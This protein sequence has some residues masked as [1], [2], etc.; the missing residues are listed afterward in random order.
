MPRRL[1]SL[2]LLFALAA[3]GAE[4][5]AQAPV[6]AL[7]L[8]V[9]Q[10]GVYRVAGPSLRDAGLVME[11]LAVENLHLST[12]GQTVP[13][14]L[15]GD[16]LVFYGRASRSRYTGEQVYILR[17]GQPGLAM[18]EKSATPAG[19]ALE[20]VERTLT[21]EENWEYLAESRG[22]AAGEP[23]FWQSLPLKGDLTLPLAIA[24]PAGGSGQLT[25]VFYG[26]SHHPQEN[27]DHT[28]SLAVNGH[29]QQTISWEG[30][31]AYS[32]TLSLEPGTLVAGDNTL[33]LANVP[34]TFLDLMKLDRLQLSYPALPQAVQDRLVFSGAAGQVTLQG[35][36]AT[37]LLL[38]IADPSAPAVLVGWE[39]TPDG[40]TLGLDGA[41]V[42]AATGPDGFLQPASIA[43]L[44]SGGWQATDNQADLLIVTT[45]ALA[46]ALAP[47][48]AAREEQGL[49]VALAPVAEVYDEFGA[50][51]ATPE[52]INRFLAYTLDAWSPP[53]PRYL[54][55]VGDATLDYRGYLAQRPENP[56]TPPENVVP[57]YLVPVS[58]GGETVSDARL[59]DAD[60]DRR[61][62][63]AV[64]RW[65]VDDAATVRELVERTLAYEAG[66]A[67]GRALFTSDGSSPEFAALTGRLLADVALPPGGADRLDGPASDALV[68][69]WNEGAWLVTYAGHGSLQLWG[70]DNILSTDMVSELSPANGVPIVLQLTCLTGLFAQPEI[71]SLSE[72]LLAQEGGPVLVVAATSLTLSSQQ[73]PFA[74]EFLAALQDPAVARIGDALQRAKMSLDVELPA[75]LEISDTFGLLGD[76]SALIVRP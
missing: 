52:S 49:A 61:P 28:L 42:V 43:P 54:L 39:A 36:S 1:A 33:L 75:L 13:F 72:R 29:P 73:E 8:V 18:A 35:F 44:R 27:P 10:E 30:Q 20:S 11:E 37:P 58:F 14:L 50:G 7:R 63:L 24:P 22:A 2:L 47:L 67:P 66:T 34:E 57:P 17:A 62:D 56:V 71:T 32:M 23:W 55:L 48:V 15:D 12:E 51:M 19:P 65:P 40:A 21:F 25:A 60:G 3:C 59:A 45:D 70:Q 76:P 4:T 41:D 6:E 31:T 9:E 64:G 38:S 46:P 53:A 26:A 69:A 74:R 5:P 68:A 16:S